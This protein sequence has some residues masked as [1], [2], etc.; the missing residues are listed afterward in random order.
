MQAA[1]CQQQCRCV[2]GAAGRGPDHSTMHT[3]T[4]CCMTRTAARAAVYGRSSGV[5]ARVVGAL[6]RLAVGSRR[7]RCESNNKADRNTTTAC[8]GAT[9]FVDG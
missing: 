3:T 1:N 5:T 8:W 7:G 2:G 9:C 6:L 4:L